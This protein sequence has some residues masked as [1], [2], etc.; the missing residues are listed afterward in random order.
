MKIILLLIVFGFFAIGFVLASSADNVWGWAWSE[1]IGWISFN[2]TNTNWCATSNYGVNIE[3]SGYFSGYAWSENIGWIS[4]NR[5]E[6]G[7]PPTSPDYNPYLAK[8]DLETGKVSG[9]ARALAYGDGWSGWIKLRGRTTEAVP[10]EYGVVID[11]DSGE[12]SG[13]AWSDMVI[14]WISF[15]CKNQEVCET[16][17]YKVKT[18]FAF[19]PSVSNLH[20]SWTPCADSLHPTL[21]WEYNDGT[22]DGYEVEIYSDS[23][24]SN[25]IYE[26][27]ATGAISTAHTANYD[28]GNCHL[29]EGENGFKNSPICD[30]EY[31]TTYWWRVKA[32]RTETGVWSDWSA[33]DSFTTYLHRW[34]SPNF[35][36][37]ASS[38][39]PW[40]DCSTLRPAV[41]EI[42]YF[43]N[44]S[45]AFG[46]AI[47]TSWYWDFGDGITSTLQNPSHFY[48]Q[49]RNY[50][51]ILEVTDSNGYSCPTDPEDI[52]FRV[53]VKIP[54]PEWKE[55]PPFIWL[56][57]FFASI[58][59]NLGKIF[60]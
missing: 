9:W 10:K 42:I 26:Y 28:A 27:T 4:F 60:S 20:D 24:L 37:S 3:N 22:P 44:E 40:V 35:K 51:V 2:C 57:N 39:G 12:F 16:S 34:P 50:S 38:T 11:K 23:A 14:G 29:A 7:P 13:W 6:T 58:L 55:I 49:P 52:K 21:N 19:L 32:K 54:L 47:T 43:H 5:A 31:G 25:L 8:V 45:E 46:G 53:T 15:N 33:P 1:N 48:S 30:L 56:K 59:E 36:C 17:D 18:S 41:N